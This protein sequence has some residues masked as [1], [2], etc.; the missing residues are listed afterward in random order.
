MYDKI[1]CF[2][3]N[4]KSRIDRKQHVIQNIQGN[5]RNLDYEFVPAIEPDNC[6]DYYEAVFG[7]KLISPEITPRMCCR[8][9]HIYILHTIVE[10]NID[11]QHQGILICENDV[12]FLVDVIARFAALDHRFDMLFLASIVKQSIRINENLHKLLRGNSTCC[13]C[14][15]SQFVK[16]YHEALKEKWLYFDRT[17]QKIGKGFGFETIQNPNHG[18]NFV[19]DHDILVVNPLWAIPSTKVGINYSDLT[20]CAAPKP[21]IKRTL[22][23]I[24]WY[25]SDWEDNKF[26]SKNWR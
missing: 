12:E 2:V 1:K 24:Y 15:D 18:Q 11:S 25:T 16:T 13:Y 20:E 26:Y 23:S 8:L 9:S 6:G 10:K 5:C 3:I 21:Y 17:K 22:E 4:L 14:V 7:K 19:P